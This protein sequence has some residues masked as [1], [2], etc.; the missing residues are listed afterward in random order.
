MK[1][2]VWYTEEAS[3]DLGWAR[4][5]SVLVLCKARLVL[6]SVQYVLGPPTSSLLGDKRNKATA[7]QPSFSTAFLPTAS[8]YT[9]K[10][11][12]F[13][14]ES[15]PIPSPAHLV[16]WKQKQTGPGFNSLIQLEPVLPRHAGD[17]TEFLIWKEGSFA[18]CLHSTVAASVSSW[19]LWGSHLLQEE[20]QTWRV[21]LSKAC[22]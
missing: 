16:Q 18:G 22:S 12:V 15:N 7:K 8:D 3:H 4:I 1:F 2:G 13:N 10:Y 17:S 20:P 6:S 19:S 21:A 5:S 14:L 9:M 11:Q